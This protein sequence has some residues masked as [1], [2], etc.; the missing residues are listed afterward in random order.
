MARYGLFAA[1]SKLSA[2][3]IK[4]SRSTE[5][6]AFAR[7]SNRMQDAGRERATV[8]ASRRALSVIYALPRGS[9]KMLPANHDQPTRDPIPAGDQPVKSTDTADAILR[10][11][12]S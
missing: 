9:T 8:W 1:S 7:G 4:H 6:F 11:T 5:P 12:T 10:G 3:P 2:D